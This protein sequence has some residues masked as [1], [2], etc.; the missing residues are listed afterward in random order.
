M[1]K[2]RRAGTVVYNEAKR[3]YRIRLTLE[4]GSRP[5]IDLTPTAKSP[6]AESRAREVAA[7]R[8]KIARERHLIAED[9]GLK[10]HAAKSVVVAGRT[11]ESVSSWFD[12]YYKAAAIGEVGRKNRGAP[13]VSAR[14]R[15]RRFETWIEPLIGSLPI[16]T[17]ASDALRPVVTGLDKQIRIRQTF[18]GLGAK[19]PKGRKPGLSAKAA[20]NIWGELTAGFREASTSKHDALRVRTD[21]PTRGVQ[22]PNGDE[23]REQAAL[24]SS[25]IAQLLRCEA[26]PHRRRVLYAMASYAGLRAGELRGLMPDAVDLEHDVINVRRQNRAGKGAARTKT[27]AGRRQVPIEPTLRPLLEALVGRA[28]EGKPLLHVP[29]PEDCAELVRKDLLTA[30]CDREELFADDGERQHFTFHG[31]RHT[32]LTHWAV[33]GRPLQWLL[34]A[35]GHTSYEVT[36]RYIDQAM[37]LRTSFGTPHPP[38]P[39]SLLKH[40]PSQSGS[41]SVRDPSSNFPFSLGNMVT[42]TGIEPVLPT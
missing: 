26:V 32:C 13:Q 10:P 28:T 11:G 17:I 6:I 21:D 34:V 29:P 7:E 9:F 5:W 15:R 39:P 38:L 3:C 33:A 36:Q 40:V 31:L 20:R 23:S 18:Y 30:G 12:R 41:Q 16:A 4:D 14:D 25:E 8:S 37:V 27:R 2:D 24:Y 35:A 19:Q 22:P 1:P 42:P